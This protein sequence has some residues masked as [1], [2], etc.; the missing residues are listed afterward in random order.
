MAYNTTDFKGHSLICRNYDSQAV[1]K[2]GR[3][4][5]EELRINKLN[6]GFP[7]MINTKDL[8]SFHFY[9]EYP[10]GIIKIATISKDKLDYKIIAELT[11]KECD[12]I[13]KKYRLP[14]FKK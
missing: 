7:F 12:E 14:N 4:A 10:D 9:L 2:S 3:K 8:P 1:G 11:L 6:M 13:R 5:V